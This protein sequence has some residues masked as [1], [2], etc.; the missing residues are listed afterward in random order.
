MPSYPS[1]Y[2]DDENA[3]WAH[4]RELGFTQSKCV[5]RPPSPD[6]DFE[7]YGRATSEAINYLVGEWDWA[8]QGH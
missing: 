6:F 7:L 4:L 3:A 5:I 8:Y 2:W 1:D